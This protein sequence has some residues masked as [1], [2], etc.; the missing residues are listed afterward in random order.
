MPYPVSKDDSQW[1]EELGP[2]RFQILRKAGTERAWTGEL[3]GE[4]RPWEFSDVEGVGMSYLTRAPS[5][6]QGQVGRL[7]GIP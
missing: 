5:L 1:L 3:L 7:S 2:E 6:N 4:K